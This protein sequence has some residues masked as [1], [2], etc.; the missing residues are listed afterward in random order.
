MLI[1]VTYGLVTGISD[2]MTPAGLAYLTMPLLGN[3]LDDAHALL[4]QR[5]A[6][7][8][9][10]L[11]AALRLAA[12]HAALVDAHAAPARRGRLVAA[13]PGDRLAQAIDRGL[14]V[15]LDGAH[16]GAS[17]VEQRLRGRLL[18]GGDRVVAGAVATAMV[19]VRPSAAERRRRPPES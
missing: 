2:A 10:H 7:D 11:G 6:Q 19:T 13:G 1:G 15:G 17:A 14:V 8:A 12:A 4:P 16:R 9:L 18:L 3:L 5:V